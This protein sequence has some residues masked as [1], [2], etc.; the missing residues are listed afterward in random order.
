MSEEQE[1]TDGPA[2]KRRMYKRLGM[3]LVALL[4]LLA[5][6]LVPP[7]ISIGRYKG[8]ITRMI[9]QSLGR[10]VR[11]SSVELRLLPRPGFVLTDLT[12]AEDP[13]YGAEP[14]LHANTVTAS[15]GFFALWRGKLEISRISVDE[16]S[17]N[18]V[19]TGDGQ[20]NLDPI[21]KTA[22]NG[23][24][25]AAAPRPAHVL[26]YLEATNSRVNIKNGT[27]KLPF[28]LMNA[29]LSFWEA[30]PGTW[31]LQLRGQPA[32]TD[33]SLASADTGIVRL[34]ATMHRASQLRLMPIHVDME[35][36]QAQLGQLS[37]LVLGSDPGWRGDLTG[38]MQLDGTAISALV[39]TRLKATNVHRTE[40]APADPLDF[41][42]N[43]SFTY[44]YST[45]SMDKLACDS[46]LGEGHVRLVG[47]LPARAP[48]KLTVDVQRVPVSAGLDALRTVR[49]GIADD[50]EARGTVSGQLSYDPAAVDTEPAVRHRSTLKP[51]KAQPAASHL[52]GS[53]T[54]E[55]FEL[56]GGGLSQ[57]VQAAKIELVPAPAEDGQPQALAAELAVP[58]GGASPLEVAVR[59]ERRGY[60]VGA[61]GPAALKRLREL[62]GVA[63]VGGSAGLDAFKGEA[64]QLDL[65]A[66]GHWLPEERIDLDGK[67]IA[68]TDQLSGTVTLHDV[69][70]AAADLANPVT[71]SDATLHL[72]SG[73]LVW[74]PVSFAYGPVKGTATLLVLLECP[75]GE[76][77]PPKLDLHF[78][79]L[80]TASLQAALLGAQKPGTMLSTL[81]ER[82]THRS[83]P[84]WPRLDGTIKA[85]ALVMG[86]ITFEKATIA[87]RVLPASAEFSSIEA[88]AL[89]GHLHA[90]GSVSSNDKPEYSFEGSFENLTGPALCQI[91]KLHCT[92]GTVNGG[93]KLTLAGY[94]GNDLAASAAGNLSFDWRKGA[95]AASGAA[96]PK[97]LARFTR[98]T[99]EATIGH[100]A[101]AIKQSQ[102]LQGG[103]TA[104]V[105][106]SIT[107]SESPKIS[108]PAVKPEQSARR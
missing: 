33:V 38:Q 108:F 7:M 79:K 34:D 54:I 80:D 93:G 10:P 19:R 72:G 97:P 89:G 98:W 96:V 55:G 35:W 68:D 78:E 74:D 85:D 83:T 2:R 76:Q 57:P 41:D 106:A 84:L 71:I 6:L 60:Q 15:V 88:A 62:A 86:P 69:T 29:D 67:Q 9:A 30:D 82:F 31:R 99:G 11:L 87:M 73:T 52:Q 25:G 14:V 12:V 102:V 21:F 64:A 95:I 50:L 103:R 27:E 63:G 40:F 23:P 77:C 44:H 17:L 75:V 20:W 81:L 13:A 22:T 4:L 16:A 37:R 45:R 70:W 42:A 28:S 105:D 56:T 5:V 48:A 58:A 100:Q 39:K 66:R 47:E 18:L 104:G 32:R 107:L 90:T 49:N 59:I 24:G 94:S 101:L 91:L 8:Q 53:L 43:C 26:P 36:R 1:R 65:T 46:P 61:R 92:G 3:I 51:V